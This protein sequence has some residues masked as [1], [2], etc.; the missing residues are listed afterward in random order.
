MDYTCANCQ[1][2]NTWICEVNGYRR[3]C[4]NFKLDSSTL[5]KY[6]QEILAEL[7]QIINNDKID[8]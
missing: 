6:E 3:K 1:S 7:G 4:E 8:I 5:S 2:R